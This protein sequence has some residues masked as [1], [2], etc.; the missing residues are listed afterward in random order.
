MQL[1]IQNGNK[2]TMNYNN[3]FRP[4]AFQNIPFGNPG[5][6]HLSYLPRSNNFELADG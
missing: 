2:T 4:K 6:E 3:I 1:K 5:I